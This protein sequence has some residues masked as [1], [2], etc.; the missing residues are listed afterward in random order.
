MPATVVQPEA[1]QLHVLAA[2]YREGL[3]K[4][5][6]NHC[7]STIAH[8][9]YG[10]QLLTDISSRKAHQIAQSACSSWHQQAA[11]EAQH[12]S[13][14][15][16]SS[17][18]VSQRTYFACALLLLISN[19]MPASH[20]QPMRCGT[21]ATKRYWFVVHLLLDPTDSSSSTEA[22]GLST[23]WPGHAACASCE[24]VTVASSKTLKLQRLGGKRKACLWDC[25][26]IKFVSMKTCHASTASALYG[27]HEMVVQMRSWLLQVLPNRGSPGTCTVVQQYSNRKADKSSWTCRAA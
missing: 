17:L 11:V 14:I 24:Q 5:C 13:P 2:L 7:G 12:V 3:H 23:Q 27:L 26:K 15:A 6:Q 18:H 4:P 1:P 22:R 16:P 10:L 21:Q 19:T 8:A 20:Q 9:T 25:L